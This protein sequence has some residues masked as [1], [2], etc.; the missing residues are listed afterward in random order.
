MPLEKK[1]IG[2]RIYSNLHNSAWVMTTK[3]KYLIIGN[4]LEDTND[5]H[6]IIE[7]ILDDNYDKYLMIG[8]I[9]DDTD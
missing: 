9:L 7:N 4:I 2:D 8:S 6:L 1:K 5:T 3:Y